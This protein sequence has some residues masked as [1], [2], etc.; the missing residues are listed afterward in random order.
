M[1]L[2]FPPNHVQL[3]AACYPPPAAL[4]ASGSDCCPNS[5][6]LSRLTYYAANKTGKLAKLGTEVEKRIKSECKKAQAGNARNRA[7]VARGTYL[8]LL[9]ASSTDHFSFLSR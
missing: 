2:S 6:E 9:N 4:L 7:Y 8:Y 1:R 5:Q 3:I